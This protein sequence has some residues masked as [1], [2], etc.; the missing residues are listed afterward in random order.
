MKSY[1]NFNI[2]DRL[3][4]TERR[5]ALDGAVVGALVGAFVDAF[6]VSHMQHSL[7]V[8]DGVQTSGVDGVQ[9]SGTSA[10]HTPGVHCG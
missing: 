6:G 2:S 3:L 9:V 5:V 8:V 1:T 10:V 7:L 4:E